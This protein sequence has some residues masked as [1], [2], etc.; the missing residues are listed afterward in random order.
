MI[1]IMAVTP[2]KKGW[3]FY[4]MFEY[5]PHFLFEAGSSTNFNASFNRQFVFLKYVFIRSLIEQDQR[6]HELAHSRI[7]VQPLRSVLIKFQKEFEKGRAK[8]PQG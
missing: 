7:Y 5:I 6:L 1:Q 2:K 4:S 3:E 8:G